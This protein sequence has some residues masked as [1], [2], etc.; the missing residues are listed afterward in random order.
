MSKL[1]LMIST[2]LIVFIIFSFGRADESKNSGD[3]RSVNEISQSILM[4]SLFITG[5]DMDVG[6]IYIPD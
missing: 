6:K 4:K 5:I 3:K 2:F 1:N